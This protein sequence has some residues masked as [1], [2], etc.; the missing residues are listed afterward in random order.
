MPL[1]EEKVNQPSFNPAHSMG[2]CRW[3]MLSAYLLNEEI[4]KLRD[5]VPHPRYFLIP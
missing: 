2:P 4:T 5:L 1:K 3:H